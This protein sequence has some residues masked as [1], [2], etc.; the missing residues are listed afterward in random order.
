MLPDANPRASVG[1][2]ALMLLGANPRASVGL[3][4]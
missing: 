2:V 4:A 1:L 3:M